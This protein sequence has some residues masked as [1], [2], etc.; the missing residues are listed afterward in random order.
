L[1]LAQILSA[2]ADVQLASFDL[3][4]Y[5]QFQ[6]PKST[7]TRCTIANHFV[8]Y[9]T[10]PA[11]DRAIKAPPPSWIPASGVHCWL[12]ATDQYLA[13]LVASHE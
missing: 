10:N 5:G 1:L 6:R 13:E 3:R 9:T 2:V 7:R 4:S 12:I 11:D 8:G